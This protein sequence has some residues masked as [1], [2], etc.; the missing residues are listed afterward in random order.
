[1]FWRINLCG[2]TVLLSSNSVRAARQVRQ[3]SAVAGSK[4]GLYF[5]SVPISG[6]NSYMYIVL[7]RCRSI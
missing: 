6:S 7:S 4:G 2:L 5:A 3:V 1:M